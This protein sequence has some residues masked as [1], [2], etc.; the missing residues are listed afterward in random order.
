MPVTVAAVGGLYGASQTGGQSAGHDGFNGYLAG[1][2]M[3]AGHGGDSL[4]QRHRTAGIDHLG[5]RGFQQS[6]SRQEDKPFFAQVS[7]ERPHPPLT[8][9]QGCPFIYDPAKITLPENQKEKIPGGTPFY[10]NRNVE[11][12]WCTSVSGEE[13]LREALCAY[14][15]LI[16]LIDAFTYR[17]IL[18][19]KY[20]RDATLK[21][22]Y[23]LIM[24]GLLKN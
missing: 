11:L 15:S 16:S 19:Q 9:P 14:Y 5:R 21:A 12:K 7:F 23:D 3:E 2:I 10:F 6:R 17:A 20:G 22:V 8:V 24:H 18:D 13:T 4:E 1:N